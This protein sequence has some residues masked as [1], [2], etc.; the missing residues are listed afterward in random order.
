MTFDKRIE[1]EIDALLS[2][3]ETE[4]FVD[5][6]LRMPHAAAANDADESWEKLLNARLQAR[7][8]RRMREK[9]EGEQTSRDSRTAA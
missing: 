5:T 9:L 6:L 1:A 3:S 4:S 8:A 7:L 2:R